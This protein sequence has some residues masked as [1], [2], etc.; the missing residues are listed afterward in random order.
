MTTPSK[1]AMEAAR[2][3]WEHTHGVDVSC[4]RCRDT[5]TIIDTHFKGLVEAGENVIE[6]VFSMQ[7]EDRLRTALREC[8]GGA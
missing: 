5:A 1:K 2:A 3:I 4:T 8:K 7:S 6:R